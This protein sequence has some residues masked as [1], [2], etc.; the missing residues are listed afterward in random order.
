MNLWEALEKVKLNDPPVEVGQTWEIYDFD[1]E[2]LRK[3]EILAPHPHYPNEE[4][5]RRHWIYVDQGGKMRTGRNGE[6]SYVDELN[7]R[8]VYSLKGREQ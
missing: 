1:R 3:L 5:N 2:V 6:I 7:L 4:H 8:M